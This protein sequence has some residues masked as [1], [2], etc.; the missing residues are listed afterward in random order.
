MI[1]KIFFN[2]PPFG[3]SN[4]SSSCNNPA[5][6]DYSCEHSGTLDSNNGIV[7]NGVGNVEEERAGNADATIVAARQPSNN[8][9]NHTGESHPNSPPVTDVGGGVSG[10]KKSQS[11]SGGGFLNGSHGQEEAK[12]KIKNAFKNGI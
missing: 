4:G 7:E 9:G 8:S 3:D 11:S 1:K 5:T 12:E 2:Q 6:P 10:H